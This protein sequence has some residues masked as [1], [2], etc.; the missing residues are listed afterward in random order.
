VGRTKPDTTRSRSTLACRLPSRARRVRGC[1]ALAR[2]ILFA[3]LLLAITS[4]VVNQAASAAAIPRSQT[5]A[6]VPDADGRFNHGGTL[7]TSGF[8][9]YTPTF[10][11]IT[12]DSIRDDAVDPLASGG[13]DTLV[14]NGICDIAT[15]LASP[16][17]KSRVEGFVGNGGKLIIWDS[18]C[19]NTDYSGFTL[20]FTTNNPGAQGAQ[21]TLTD[22]EENPL[23]STDS[24]S[25][26]FLNAAL[27][28]SLTDA[29]GDSN[30]FT[31]FDQHWFVDLQ[32]TN[33]NGVTGPVQAYGNIGRGLVI[34]SGLDKDFMPGPS[35]D[36]AATDGASHLNRVWLLQLLQPWDPDNLPGTVKAFGLALTPKSGS[37]PTGAA[38]TMTAHVTRSSVPLS[39]VLVH[40]EVTSGPC[41][42]ASSDVVTDS[43]GNGSFTYSC[44]FAGTDTITATALVDNGTG[45]LVIV[46][47]TATE[48]WIAQAR[49]VALGD[50]YS[51]GEGN[52][53]FD[54]GTDVFIRGR[55]LNGCHRSESAWPR[56]LGVTAGDHLACSR[57]VIT[58]LFHGQERRPPDNVGQ[59]RRLRAIERALSRQNGH[60]DLV[61]ITIGGNDFGF[62]P[63]ITRCFFLNDCF[64]NFDAAVKKVRALRRPLVRALKRIQVAAPRA[65]VALVGYPR[66]FPAQQSD[67]VACGWLTPTERQRANTLAAWFNTVYTQAAVRAHVTFIS[68]ADALDGHEL[69]TNDSWMFEVNPFVYGRDQR[70]G[71]PL[72]SGQAAIAEIVRPFLAMSHSGRRPEKREKARAKL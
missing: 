57:A 34:Y 36:P 47:D 49:Y 8:P 59:I 10:T 12:P 44:P 18:E 54:P 72:S 48:E 26:S 37:D 14:L 63:S 5:I 15:Y 60:V 30:V 3:V 28:A 67:N 51:S 65:R 20:P 39:S 13:Y 32:A 58:D 6:L 50:S 33:I 38:H 31:T 25:P 70:Q 23:S 35:F 21:G 71:H 53:P 29:V 17:F 42:G 68:V 40:F 24:T 2:G 4:T 52:R 69:C 45:G 22:L 46:S 62:G 16:N 55:R 43:T 9:N 11:N 7:P 27:I 41:Q 64:H 66:I 56:L 61:T 1:V 19:Q